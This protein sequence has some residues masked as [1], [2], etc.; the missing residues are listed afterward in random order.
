MDRVSVETVTETYLEARPGLLG[1]LFKKYRIPHS[2]G[3]EIAQEAYVRVIALSHI[4]TCVRAYLFTTVDHLALNMINSGAEKARQ[5]QILY[6]DR[7]DSACV[8][9][10]ERILENQQTYLNIKEHLSRLP[11]D[12]VRVFMWVRLKGLSIDEAAHLENIDK[13]TVYRYVAWVHR[14]LNG[15]G[16][17]SRS[18]R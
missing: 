15:E 16:V 3:V 18:R 8:I 9:T 1:Y 14:A 12:K 17:L 11:P 6:M 2:T 10:P 4:P 5:K 7:F 13:R